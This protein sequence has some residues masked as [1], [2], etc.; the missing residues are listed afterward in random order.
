MDQN[1]DEAVVRDFGQEWSAFPQDQLDPSEYDKIFQDYFHLFPFNQVSNGIGLDVGCGSGRWAA[2]VAPKVHT[3]YALDASPEALAV[4]RSNCGHLANVEFLAHSVDSIPF[5]ANHFDFAYSLG[6]LHH[7]PRTQDAIKSIHKVLKPGAP[8][9]IYLYYKLDNRP[10]PFRMIWLVSDLL[11]RWISVQ[12]H[13]KK[14]LI[15]DLLAIGI[16]YPLARFSRALE[17][18]GFNVK[19]LPL[20]FYRDKS[21]YTMRTDS[22]DR[23]GTRLEQRFSKQ[24]IEKMLLDCGFTDVHF[25]DREPYWTALCCKATT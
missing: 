3:L 23:F 1:A 11:R 16:Y 10:L 25:S 22:L 21:F 14:R 12:C 18:L 4:A 20:S 9:L 6:V 5:G 17:K 24:E 19:G 7:V 13:W 2:L 15:C 8:F